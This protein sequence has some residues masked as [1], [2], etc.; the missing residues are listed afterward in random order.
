MALELAQPV[1]GN[2]ALRRALATAPL[3]RFSHGLLATG[4]LEDFREGGPFTL[5][6]PTNEAFSGMPWTFEDLLFDPAYLDERFDIFEY[7]VLRGRI[8]AEGPRAAHVTLHGESVRLGN[9]L[10]YGRFGAAR[11]LESVECG[12][13]LLHVLEQCVYPWDPK[14]TPFGVPAR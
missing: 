10:V 9:R 3:A 6:A 12:T 5:L 2:D 1:A 14:L 11:V 8:G 7:L 13:I 4:L